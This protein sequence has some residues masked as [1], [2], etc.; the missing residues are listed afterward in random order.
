M[1]HNLHLFVIAILVA[2]LHNAAARSA[3]RTFNSAFG[4]VELMENLKNVSERSRSSPDTGTT[5]LAADT[6]HFNC[7]NSMTPASLSYLPQPNPSASPIT[8]RK[9]TGM[10]AILTFETLTDPNL[11]SKNYV[12][13][14]Y[15]PPG[16]VAVETDNGMPNRGHLHGGALGG[17]G[18]DVRNIVTLYSNCNDPGMKIYENK[19]AR[20]FEQYAIGD[21]Q[22]LYEVS[23][24][25]RNPWKE[26]PTNIV[27]KAAIF[28]PFDGQVT[29]WFHVD[30]PN[31]DDAPY[32]KV[33]HYD[34]T[35]YVKCTPTP[36]P[37]GPAVATSLTCVGAALILFNLKNTC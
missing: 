2:V 12:G 27:M 26:Y 3:S 35:V 18:R 17:S 15:T 7:F 23:A 5:P 30:V 34:D 37:T 24:Q 29:R 22:V 21:C 4:K 31:T 1:Q 9:A 10:N 14:F 36:T 16:W 25:Y 20:T 28:N 11:G 33:V 19:V 8:A 6:V 13:K 32:T